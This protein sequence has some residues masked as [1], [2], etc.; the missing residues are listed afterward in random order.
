MKTAELIPIILYQLVNGDRYGYEIIKQIEDSSN[1]KITIKQPTLYSILKKLEQGRFISSYWQDSEIGGKRHYYKLTDNGKAQ[2]STYPSFEQLLTDTLTKEG[3]TLDEI[4]AKASF[5]PEPEKI[6]DIQPNNIE[7]SVS[8]IITEEIKIETIISND[9]QVNL[10]ENL[11]T[12]KDNNEIKPIHIDLTQSI[13]NSTSPIETITKEQKEEQESV[14]VT[15]VIVEEDPANKPISIFD[16]IEYDD[17]EP[18]ESSKKKED[19]TNTDADEKE[20]I[21]LFEKIE[22]IIPDVTENKLYEQL[23]PN[24]EMVKQIE[25]FN[26]EPLEEVSKEQDDEIKYVDYIDFDKDKASIKRKQAITKRIQKMSITCVTL[27]LMFI[28][29]IVLCNKYS[30]SALYYISAILVCLIIIL[31]PALL[32]SNINKI[33]LKY[34]SKP[35]KYSVSRN[36]WIKISLFL[37]F[38]IIIIAYNLSNVSQVSN[39]FKIVNFASFYAPMLFS[40]V[41]ILDFMYSILLF[42]NFR[43]K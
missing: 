3:L 24:P 42:K 25:E 14:V 12:I 19:I 34:C 11:N 43:T 32:I 40:C 1:G 2:L 20:D 18:L 17:S 16:A 6:A 30:Y 15:E 33:R 41:I 37:T 7:T 28:A 23:S 5:Q 26:K 8:P 39:I 21:K 10:D 22:P 38:V 27:L 35:F 13:S 31:Y 9:T 29:T 4:K 36:L